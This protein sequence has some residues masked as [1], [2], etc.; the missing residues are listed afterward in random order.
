[1]K[2]INIV[3]QHN[4]R[5]ELFFQISNAYSFFHQNDFYEIK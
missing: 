2:N 4:I 5:N 3:T 1:M